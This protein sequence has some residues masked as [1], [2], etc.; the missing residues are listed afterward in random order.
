MLEIGFLENVIER[1][2]GMLEINGWS[3]AP[4]VEVALFS[5]VDPDD[6]LVILS[7]RPDRHRPDIADVPTA[8]FQITIAPDLLCLLPARTTLVPS[9]AGQPLR[10]LPDCNTV[11]KG[12]AASTDAIRCEVAGGLRW[13][14]KSGGLYLPILHWGEERR[15]ATLDLLEE[16]ARA[17][18]NALSPANGTLLGVI[19]SGSLLP[20]DDDLDMAAYIHA[21]SLTDFVA[22]WAQILAT[23][24]E[25][26][27]LD[28]RFHD[29]LFHPL[30]ARGQNAID[31]WPV[32]VRSDGTF[33]DVHAAGELD[34]FTLIESVLEG[35]VV[36]IPRA[37][38]RL[39]EH[40]YGTD[41]LVP[42]PAWRPE[43]AYSNDERFQQAYAFRDAVNR[44]MIRH[45]TVTRRHV[46]S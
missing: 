14:R 37:A 15:S 23:T 4:S 17:S 19:R 34:D 39:L 29:D 18:S 5:E 10:V 3:R 25:S 12:T 16:V 13:N 46:V 11:V 35:R 44:E 27:G 9:A 40:C 38:T 45:V 1:P 42:D 33:V 20:H 30:I 43:R 31:C 41:Y 22:K 32:W 6:A 28:V 26:A 36:R 7:V 21:E 8:G 24:A 2:D